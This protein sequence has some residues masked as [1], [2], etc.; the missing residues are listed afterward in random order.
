MIGLLIFLAIYS[1]VF[2]TLGRFYEI[3]ID[4]EKKE[5]KHKVK[6]LQD[7]WEATA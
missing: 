5:A 6:K 7:D 1:V 3:A 4:A 2:F